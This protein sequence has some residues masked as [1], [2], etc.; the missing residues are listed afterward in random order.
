MLKNSSLDLSRYSNYDI[1][2]LS[3]NSCSSIVS[4]LVIPKL[5]HIPLS[6]YQKNN[7]FFIL[8]IENAHQVSGDMI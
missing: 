3:R 7:L 8:Q 4:L 6:N 2:S 5:L 1:A